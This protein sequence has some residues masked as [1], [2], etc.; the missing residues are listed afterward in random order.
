MKGLYVEGFCLLSDKGGLINCVRDKSILLTI[1]RSYV[2]RMTYFLHLIKD[3][4]DAISIFFASQFHIMDA[5]A[6]QRC[7]EVLFVGHRK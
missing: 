1:L 7:V 6:E 2:Q 5:V 3:C 4:A